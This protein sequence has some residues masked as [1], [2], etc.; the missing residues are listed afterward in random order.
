[1]GLII[2]VKPPLLSLAFC[3]VVVKDKEKQEL[4]DGQK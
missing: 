1:M 3:V 2:K 4:P